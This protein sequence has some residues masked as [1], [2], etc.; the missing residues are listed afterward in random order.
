MIY[1]LL[2]SDDDSRSGCRNVSQYRNNSNSPSHD[3]THPSDHTSPTYD[4][5]HM[6]RGTN[7]L[8]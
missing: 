1:Y 5:Y 7:Y 6:T 4:I 8:Q 3:Y 2:D